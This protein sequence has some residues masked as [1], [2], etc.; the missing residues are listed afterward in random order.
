MCYADEAI[1]IENNEDD[2]QRQVHLLNILAKRNILEK[3]MMI[4]PDKTNCLLPSKE[5]KRC[6]LYYDQQ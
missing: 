3:D 1:Y 2:L 4:S 6:K 5:P